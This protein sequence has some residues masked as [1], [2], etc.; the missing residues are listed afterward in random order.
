[1]LHR[2]LKVFQVFGTQLH[3]EVKFTHIYIQISC[4]YNCICPILPTILMSLTP[5]TPTQCKTRFRSL[6]NSG[7]CQRNQVKEFGAYKH[8]HKAEVS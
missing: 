7:K 6:S 5:I 3:S 4:T 1:M 2:H 8:H